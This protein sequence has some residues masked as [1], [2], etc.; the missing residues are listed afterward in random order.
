MY[1]HTTT[2]ICIVSSIELQVHVSLHSNVSYNIQSQAS[3]S[4]IESTAT[5]ISII[6]IAELKSGLLVWLWHGLNIR[7]QNSL[8]ISFHVW[9][10]N[11]HKITKQWRVRLWMNF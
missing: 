11:Y 3:N 1:I 6:R 9:I 2:Y 4:S 10:T 7:L 8:P 5:D